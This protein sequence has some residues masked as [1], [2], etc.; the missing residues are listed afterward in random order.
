MASTTVT[1]TEP[2]SGKARRRKPVTP[3][4][5]IETLMTALVVV[6]EEI[7]YRRRAATEAN[8]IA[9]GHT[10]RAIALE[11]SRLEIRDATASA[12]RA[13]SRRAVAAM[14]EAA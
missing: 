5:A 6:D 4:A 13:R 10:V 9:H 12:E 1:Q 8:R 3:F 2:A 14:A 7:A 11:K